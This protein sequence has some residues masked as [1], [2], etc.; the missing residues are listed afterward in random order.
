MTIMETSKALDLQE[1]IGILWTAQCAVVNLGPY[2]YERVQS[3]R[4]H[5]DKQ[6]AEYMAEGEVAA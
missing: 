4:R 6:L 3:A 5:L 1:A 2:A